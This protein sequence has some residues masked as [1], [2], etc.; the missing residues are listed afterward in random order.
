M[1]SSAHSELIRIHTDSTCIE[2]ML[3]LPP[4]ALGLVLFA[5]GSGSSRLSPRNNY[6]AAQLR[7]A[8]MGTLLMDLL[9]VQEDQ[10]YQT[11]F[12]IDLLTQRLGQAIAWLRKNPVTR[13]LP[14]ALFGASTGAAAA[15]QA[16]AVHGVDIT[17][18]VSRGGRPDMA[19]RQ[20]LESVRAPTLLI[21]GGLD[22]VVIELNR[23]AFAVLRCEKRFEIIPAAT[24]L[25]EEPGT[26][27]AVAALATD[28]FL[29]HL[30]IPQ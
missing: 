6:V 28:W 7:T 29:Q 30:K 17:A 4:V 20:A 24:H 16:A 18:V 12:D 21:V 27:E 8:C 19:G 2:G 22:D 25:F 11:R 3:E 9:S 26:L 13:P 15:L 23:T 10:H 14:L 1:V 5:H